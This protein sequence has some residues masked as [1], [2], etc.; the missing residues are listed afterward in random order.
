MDA[1]E[2]M[3]FMDDK[4]MIAECRAVHSVYEGIFRGHGGS[5]VGGTL[6][7]YVVKRKS[8]ARPHYSAVAESLDGKTA[9]GNLEDTIASAIL[10]VHWNELFD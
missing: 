5:E 7:V 8:D 4:G 10:G 9:T 3:T 1:F 6:T 2:V